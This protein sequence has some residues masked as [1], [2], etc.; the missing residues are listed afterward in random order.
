MTL[1]DSSPFQS[2]PLE[3]TTTSPRMFWQTRNSFN[4]EN[5]Y[6][7]VRSGSPSP[8]RRSSIERLQK[9]SRVKNSNILALEQSRRQRFWRNG[10]AASL[11]GPS[12]KREQDEPAHPPSKTAFRLQ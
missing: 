11:R 7:N 8:C 2:S 9:A 6:G 12:A 10:A 3:S 5:S 1:T 4:S